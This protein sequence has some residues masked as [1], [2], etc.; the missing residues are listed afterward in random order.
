MWILPIH[1]L[2][3]QEHQEHQCVLTAWVCVSVWYQHP[4]D[5]SLSWSS[6]HPK[7]PTD[8][9]SLYKGS[10]VRLTWDFPQ[11]HQDQKGKLNNS[12]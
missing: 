9:F 1:I 5:G 8:E 11:S 7:N 2:L 4:A 12:Q 6:C 10:P 3:V